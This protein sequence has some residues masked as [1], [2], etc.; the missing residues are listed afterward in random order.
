M[1]H[2]KNATL[3]AEKR[4][5]FWLFFACALYASFWLIVVPWLILKVSHGQ[6]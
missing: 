6:C 4:F 2:S 5:D 1:T 3:P